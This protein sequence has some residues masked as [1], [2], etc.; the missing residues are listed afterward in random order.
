MKKINIDTEEGLIKTRFPDGQTHIQIIPENDGVFEVFVSLNSN[1]KLID[2][3]QVADAIDGLG[4]IKLSLTIKYLLGARYDRRMKMGDSFDLQVVAK[5][6]NICDFKNIHILDP[7]SKVSTLLINNSNAIK[8]YEM[9]VAYRRQDA[10][11]ICPDKGAALKTNEYQN[12]NSNIKEIIYCE[13]TRDENGAISLM[14]FNPEKCN[15]RNCVIIDDICDGGGTFLAIANQI[16][17]A[18]LTLIVTHGIFSKGIEVLENKFDEIIC[19]DS[20]QIKE[21]SNKLKVVSI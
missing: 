19:S 17:P 7:H 15:G 2:L 4:G 6:I 10:V 14:V 21:K 1:E 16:K 8:N 20:L 9:V 18:H 12:W 11:L 13:K 5:L 3:L